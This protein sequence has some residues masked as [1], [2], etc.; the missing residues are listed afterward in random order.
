MIIGN[1]APSRQKNS[2]PA[3]NLINL[4]HFPKWLRESAKS[5]LYK[6]KKLRNSEQ[7]QKF[8]VNSEILSRLKSLL[9]KT[10]TWIST[11]RAWALHWRQVVVMVAPSWHLGCWLPQVSASFSQTGDDSMQPVLTEV[12]DEQATLC[13][14]TSYPHWKGQINKNINIWSSLFYEKNRLQIGKS[15]H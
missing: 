11:E 5:L 3:S 14:V 15:I 6:T 4:T 8:L 9:I 12:E 13:V 1:R 2:F 7:S 10:K